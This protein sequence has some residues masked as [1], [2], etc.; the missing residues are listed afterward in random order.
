MLAVRKER[1]PAARWCWVLV[2]GMVQ[3]LVTLR[4]SEVIAGAVF[5]AK[6]G[7]GE[8]EGEVGTGKIF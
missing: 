1:N 3:V 6:V 4:Q 7:G 5:P 8:G 2:Q